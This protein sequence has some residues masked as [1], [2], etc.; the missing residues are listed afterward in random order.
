MAFQYF[1]GSMAFFGVLF[2]V[3]DILADHVEDYFEG[4]L[5]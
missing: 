3:C 5:K 4:R 1:I 2:A